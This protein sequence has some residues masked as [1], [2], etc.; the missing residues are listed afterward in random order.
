VLVPAL[1]NGINIAEE[2]C[3]IQALKGP[4]GALMRRTRE[5]FLGQMELQHVLG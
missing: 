5:L 4:D 2:D 1:V 3:W